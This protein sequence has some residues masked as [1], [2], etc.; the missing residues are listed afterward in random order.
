MRTINNIN[1]EIKWE[2][3]SLDAMKAELTKRKAN[4][5]PT[6]RLLSE[7]EFSQITLFNLRDELAELEG[8]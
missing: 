7:I 2:Q 4:G 1:I 3:I 5:E 6:E 8:R